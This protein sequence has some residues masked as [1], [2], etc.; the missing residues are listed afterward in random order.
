MSIPSIAEAF[1][2]TGVQYT[3]LTGFSA[4][5]TNA[6]FV[7]LIYRNVLGRK[8]GADKPGLDYWS[9]ELSNGNATRGNLVSTILDSAHSFKGDA[10]WGWVAD[11]L[12]NKIT[13]AQKVSVDWGLNYLTPDASIANGMAI[14]KAVTPTNTDVAIALVGIPL[15]TITLT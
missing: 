1:Y 15:D 4:S 9:G 2:A 13:V 8:D 12:D 3:A 7:N 11:L 10:T 6:D 14:A 5:M